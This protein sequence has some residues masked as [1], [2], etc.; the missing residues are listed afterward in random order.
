MSGAY[1]KNPDVIFRKIAD[2]FVLV[3][4]RQKAIDLKSIYTMNETAACI[5]EAVDGVKT[6]A[7]IGEHLAGAFDASLAQTGA[8][9]NEILAQFEAL[10]FI[11]RD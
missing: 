1:S 4:I 2:E 3:P 10:G 7:Q 11:K 8:D 6:S 5:W 9:V